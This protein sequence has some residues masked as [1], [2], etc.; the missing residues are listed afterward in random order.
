MGK[1]IGEL[2]FKFQLGSA[3]R[4]FVSSSGCAVGLTIRL[5]YLLR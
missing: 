5:R 2:K 4:D 1:E 3:F